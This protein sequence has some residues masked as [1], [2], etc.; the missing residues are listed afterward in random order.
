[1]DFGYADYSIAKAFLYLLDVKK[2]DG[3]HKSTIKKL[4][5]ELYNRSLIPFTKLFDSNY[6]LM[7]PKTSQGI[8]TSFSPATWGNGFVEGNSWHH[9]FP[10]Y[11][12]SC[13]D[14]DEGIEG[15]SGK[16]RGYLSN[17]VGSKKFTCDE[18]LAGLYGGKEE[19]VK[20]LKELVRTNSNFSPGSYGRDIHEMKEAR[21]FSMGQ[22]AHNN[23][24]S[25]HILH[26]F[27]LLGEG[28]TTNFLVKKVLKTAYGADFYSG[29]EDN[30][31]MSSWYVL[32]SLGLFSVT[33]GTKYY[34]PSIPIFSEVKLYRDFKKKF[35]ISLFST[36]TD[37]SSS[38]TWFSS[39]TSS[40]I[41]S[42]D[43]NHYEFFSILNNI[44]N[45]R[46]SNLEESNEYV[47][48]LTLFNELIREKKN[49][50]Y[51][52]I[53]VKNKK[54]SLKTNQ[55]NKI[56]NIVL[57]TPTS[58]STPGKRKSTD[59]YLKRISLDEINEATEL[60]YYLDN[61]KDQSD[62]DLI[63][64][65]F[66]SENHIDKE[67]VSHKSPSIEDIEAEKQE[68]I[69]QIEAKDEE[70]KQNEKK[71]EEEVE[72]LKQKLL[73]E[74]QQQEAEKKRIMLKYE[75]EITKIKTQN[76]KIVQQIALDHEKNLSQNE[77]IVEM[78]E[79]ERIN[80][81]SATKNLLKIHEEIIKSKEKD[82]KHMED[83]AN[84]YRS[85]L[86]IILF[87]LLT[88]TLTYILFF[89]SSSNTRAFFS[90]I[91]SKSSTLPV[92]KPRNL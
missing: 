18:G 22:Y 73:F 59:N 26:L 77:E 29:D 91:F 7:V 67:T 45:K 37:K 43:S 60:I 80:D 56:K 15:E 84:F 85:F 6:G 31:E 81:K 89:S 23:Q 9:S 51:L 33:S 41:S 8:S 34:V 13:V 1:M 52:T 65:H 76:E 5:E 40:S 36:S 75:E 10:P 92:Y 55:N 74:K 50:L 12:I 57:I 66:Q 30:G 53:S 32:S 48:K 24:P 62:E 90:T 58:S 25:H 2:Y 38:K 3:K 42:D 78:S 70:I 28:E 72:D 49:N 47:S 44:N 79:K 16:L 54:F 68:V 88:F 83:L 64:K 46:L 14:E 63:L 21:A 87:L 11:A 35:D 86:L 19:L 71:Y 17:I 82:I 20:K 39:T 69:D 27:A 4:S 61:E